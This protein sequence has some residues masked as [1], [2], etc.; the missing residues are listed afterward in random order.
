MKLLDIILLSL[1]VAFFIIGVHQ[2]MTVGL[3]GAYWAI[4]IAVVMFFVYN[5][6]KKKS[7]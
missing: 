1:S 2:I 6:R 4:M 3:V 5:L 7:T